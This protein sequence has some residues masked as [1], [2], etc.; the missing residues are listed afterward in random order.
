MLLSNPKIQELIE[1]ACRGRSQIKLTIGTY[2][3]CEKSILVF[4][5]AGEIPNENYTYEIGSITKT[6][7]TSLMMKYVLEQKMSLD[8]SISKYVD[9][10]DGGAYY[11]TLGRLA[12]HTAGYSGMLPTIGM[13]IPRVLLAQLFGKQGKFP[14]RLDLEKKKQLLRKN[15]LQ[16]KEYPWQYSNF[17]VALIG[18]AV[19]IVSGRGYRD[20]M[21][22]FLVKDL[23]LLH[24][25]TG[26]C[27]TK[28]L[29]GFS[30]K[31]KSLGN[32]EWGEDLSAPAGD[33]SSTAEDVLNYAKMNMFEEKPYL[34][35]CHQKQ[36]NISQQANT[37]KQ[38][39]LSMGL[40]W[41]LH[42]K[43]SCILHNGVTGA[44]R[45]YLA[46]DKERKVT[47]LILVNYAMNPFE[48]EELGLAVLEALQK[49]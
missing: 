29:C 5:E 36:I 45:S 7:T 38:E 26:T 44:F 49:K 22:D 12:T 30:E 9:G 21:N 19:G 33:I 15:K 27:T 35:F 2:A 18:Y 6:F 40:G 46:I 24:S 10:L 11:P 23:G 41:Y 1:K 32:W 14:F 13:D 47:S 34:S 25:Y 8:D 37:F 43:S 4:G 16:D 48:V 3:D 20:T 39:N 28:N 31:N 42:E 17:G